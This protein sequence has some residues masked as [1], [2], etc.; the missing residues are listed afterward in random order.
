MI[1]HP[2][3]T[4]IDSHCHIDMREDAEKPRNRPDFAR[5]PVRFDAGLTVDAS[6]AVTS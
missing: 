3:L 5:C 2:L 4:L 6:G 1:D